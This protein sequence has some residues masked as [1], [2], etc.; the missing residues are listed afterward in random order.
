MA[1]KRNTEINLLPQKEFEES[2]FGRALKWLV[3]TF[4][5]IVIATEMVVMTAF[6][7]RFYLDSRSG[8]LID[9]INQKSAIISSYSS[10]ESQY[11]ATQNKLNAFSNFSGDSS[12]ASPIIEE[13]SSKI[14]S[15]VTLTEITI[16]NSKVLITAQTNDNSSVSS[17]INSLTSSQNLTNISLF[18]ITQKKDTASLSFTISAVMQT[19]GGQNGSTGS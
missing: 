12:K 15:N 1:R 5:Y 9:A 18:S 4:R 16:D 2:T 14:P 10:F 17:F 8:D 19:R 11:R 6:L 7:S 13:I 3:T